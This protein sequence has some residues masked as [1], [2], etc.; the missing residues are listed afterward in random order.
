MES[1]P[2]A[3]TS[4]GTKGDKLDE[5]LD[6]LGENGLTRRPCSGE[7]LAVYG[8]LRRFGGG[9]WKVVVFVEGG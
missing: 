2:R 5:K 3:V 7:D 4:E 1:K 8:E 9:W 6:E